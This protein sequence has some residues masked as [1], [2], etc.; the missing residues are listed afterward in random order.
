MGKLRAGAFSPDS[1][2]ILLLGGEKEDLVH[3]YDVGRNEQCVRS[4]P[5]LKPA[6]NVVDAVERDD[7]VE[8]QMEE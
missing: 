8:A 6:A 4:F 1:S 3:I 5:G 7:D 2:N